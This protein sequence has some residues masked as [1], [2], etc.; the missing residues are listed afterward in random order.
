MTQVAEEIEARVTKKVYEELN[1]TKSRILGALSKLDNFL[2]NS[3]VW[4]QAAITPENSRNYDRE[5][6]GVQ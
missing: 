1:R 4:F 3:Q 5:N 6:Q 2:L